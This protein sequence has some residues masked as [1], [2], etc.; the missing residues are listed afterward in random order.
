V[1]CENEPGGKILPADEEMGT[2]ASV[3]LENGKCTST[4]WK[5]EQEFIKE[6]RE[7]NHEKKSRHL[8]R[9]GHLLTREQA[10][11]YLRAAQSDPLEALY[12]LALTTG[13]RWADLLT[14]KWEQVD[15]PQRSGS[16]TIPQREQGRLQITEQKTQI[17]RSL[18]LIALASEALT[19]HR[20]RQDEQQLAAGESWVDQGLVFCNTRGTSL[21]ASHV[22]RHSFV[23]LRERASLPL[24]RFHDLRPSAIH[25]LVLAGVHPRVIQEMFGYRSS[26]VTTDVNVSSSTLL[27]LQEEAVQRLNAL[28]LDE[29]QP[30]SLVTV[31]ADKHISHYW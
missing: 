14:L 13:M 31:N 26:S 19:R 9:Q 12:L 4:Y 24:L 10:R 3:P 11:H 15:L 20:L 1:L 2:G 27:S 30:M 25:L 22:R 7:A 28:L 6:M 23:P 21:D 5:R 16:E 29:Q 17:G 8:S 18:L